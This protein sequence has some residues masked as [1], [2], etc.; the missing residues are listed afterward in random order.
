MAAKV[1]LD[2]FSTASG[3]S[4]NWHKSEAHWLAEY[5]QPEET[6]QLQWLWKAFYEPGTLLGFSFGSG[7]HADDMFDTALVKLKARL[8]KWDT[9]L[10]TLQGKV[11]VENHLIASGLWYMLTLNAICSHRLH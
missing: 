4:I 1:I 11:V 6:A 5:E 10:L 2:K 9:F 7:L 8:S 3:L